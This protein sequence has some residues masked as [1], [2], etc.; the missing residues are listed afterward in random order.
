MPKRLAILILGALLAAS[1]ARAQ[2][3]GDALRTILFDDSR[4]EPPGRSP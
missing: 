2:S 4:G 3:A 1:D